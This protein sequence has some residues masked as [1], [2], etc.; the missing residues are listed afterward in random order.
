MFFLYSTEV[1]RLG[2]IPTKKQAAENSKVRSEETGDAH[3][4]WRRRFL[5]VIRRQKKDKK[6][7]VKRD[8]AD[9]EFDEEVLKEVKI[10]YEIL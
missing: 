3:D 6:P 8:L 4:S 2:L 7:V 10:I 5:R 9:I 1:R